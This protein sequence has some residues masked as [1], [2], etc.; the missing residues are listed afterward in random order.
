MPAGVRRAGR[1]DVDAASAVLAD[2]FAD[3]P[4]TQ[5][6]VEELPA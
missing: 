3:Y 4:W 6:T 2:T 5:W 1:A